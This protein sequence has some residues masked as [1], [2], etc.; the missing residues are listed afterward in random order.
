MYVFMYVHSIAH[1]MGNES[2]RAWG[3][4]RGLTQGALSPPYSHTRLLFDLKL[5]LAELALVHRDFVT[6]PYK[7][8]LRLTALRA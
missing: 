4:L 1:F 8:G 2:K 5:D 3:S 6:H 7:S